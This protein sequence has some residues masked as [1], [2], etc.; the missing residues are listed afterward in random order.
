LP[1]P[2]VDAERQRRNELREADGRAIGI[3]AHARS[4]RLAAF[5]VCVRVRTV[6]PLG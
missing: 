5:S 6:I 2:E 4:L 1:E 3:A